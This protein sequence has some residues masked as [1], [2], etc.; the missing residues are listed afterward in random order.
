MKLI[1]KSMLLSALLPLIIILS[2]CIMLEECPPVHGVDIEKLETS[3]SPHINVTRSELISASAFVSAL[4]DLVSNE[5]VDSITVDLDPNE[6]NQTVEL[7]ESLFN[8]E[9]SF[10][11]WVIRYSDKFY[12]IWFWIV[13]C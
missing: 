4:D 1:V 12:R 5:T 2:G 11:P 7:F 3:A 6:W 9:Y 13:V 8:E 10:D